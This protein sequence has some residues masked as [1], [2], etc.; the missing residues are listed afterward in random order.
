MDGVSPAV[1]AV[2]LPLQEALLF[3]LVDR[4]YHPAWLEG[5]PFSELLLRAA[6]VEGHDVE[7]REVPGPQP[8]RRQPLGQACRLTATKQ[9]EQIGGADGQRWP[10]FP[11][12]RAAPPRTESVV[13]LRTDPSLD[14]RLNDCV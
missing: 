14:T 10:A 13:H 7:E 6:L 4:A 1:S 11:A 3:Q 8:E 2:T 5:Q 9:A 12:A